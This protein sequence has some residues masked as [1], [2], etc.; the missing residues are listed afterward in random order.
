MMPSVYM[1]NTMIE[2]RSHAS[3]YVHV[4]DRCECAR[5]RFAVADVKYLA[6]VDWTRQS[7]MKDNIERKYCF[8]VTLALYLPRR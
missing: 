1:C 2:S 4:C 7:T 3:L 5:W 6:S 8:G